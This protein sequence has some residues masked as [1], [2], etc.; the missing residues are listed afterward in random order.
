MFSIFGHTLAL[1]GTTTYC[2]ILY[3]ELKVPSPHFV[4]AGLIYIQLC[5]DN[6]HA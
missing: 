2:T 4:V 1:L 3:V 5:P 6:Q